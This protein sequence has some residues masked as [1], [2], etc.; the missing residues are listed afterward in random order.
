MQMLYEL[1]EEFTNPLNQY[2]DWVLSARV[3]DFLK[4]KIE[5]QI[6][7]MQNAGEPTEKA[8]SLD[9]LMQIP[10]DQH[11][12]FPPD[13]FGINLNYGFLR[14]QRR[15]VDADFFEEIRQVSNSLD[16]SLQA[17]LGARFCALKMYYPPEGFIAWHTNWNVPG[18]NIIFT[19]SEKGQ[20]HWRHI[21]SSNSSSHVPDPENLVH[22]DD[23]PGWHCKVGYFGN[24]NEFDKIVWHSAHTSEPRITV[25]YVIFEKLIWENMVE[26]LRDR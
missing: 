26:E 13:Q 18:Y 23:V 6:S 24:K 25:S 8:S 5:W 19:Y 17:S 1:G 10:H 14:N 7:K 22:V 2:R 16:E 20:G 21:D 12:G 3:Q 9:Y 11:D 15:R 4:T